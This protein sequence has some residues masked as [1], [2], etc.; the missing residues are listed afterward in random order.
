MSFTEVF[1]SATV[2]SSES[3]LATFSLT[4]DQT[5]FWAYN[6]S[7]STYQ[8]ADIMEFSTTAG[9]SIAMPPANQVSI[10]ESTLIRNIGANQFEVKGAGGA[11]LGTVAAGVAKLFY[12]SDNTTVA[13]VWSVLT[14]GTGTSAADA[15]TLQGLGLLAIGATL[16]DS[17]P[18][19]TTS[20]AY[21]ITTANRANTLVFTGGSVNCTLPTL[22]TAVNG[23]SVLIKN[24]GSGTITFVPQGA[25]VIDQ[26]T[27]APGESVMLIAGTS[28]VT[29]GYGRSSTFAFTRLNKDV[30]AFG[31]A[32]ASVDSVNK[33]VNFHG[34]PTGNLNA[35][36]PSVPA[37]YYLSSSLTVRTVTV[38][39]STGT[40]VALSPGDSVIVVCD[41]VNMFVALSAT[42]SNDISLPSGTA[43]IPS[44]RFAASSGT[45]IYLPSG[46]MLGFSL[47]GVEKLRLDTYYMTFAGLM[48]LGRDP[49]TGTWASSNFNCSGMITASYLGGD[50]VRLE[51]G[52][53][54]SGIV[55]DTAKNWTL[56]AKDFT[57]GNLGLG[58]FS[59]TGA[60]LSNISL[61]MDTSGWTF[62]GNVLLGGI[63][64][65]NQLGFTSGAG[66]TV[67]QATS[68]STGVTLN[69]PCGTI[70]TAGDA[71]TANTSVGFWF[72][73][74][75]IGVN[76]VMMASVQ[77]AIASKYEIK[78]SGNGGSGANSIGV[79]IKNTTGGSL[80]EVLVINFVV[81][82]GSSV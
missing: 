64:G 21:V 33:I 58:G 40:G 36:F 29:V 80:S 6:S 39:T 67:T 35:V 52:L 16:N 28:W 59:M 38:K 43:A 42:Y 50:G 65:K 26:L 74:T 2:P 3:K 57:M 81:I 49:V 71:L 48:E 82:K 46:G 19:V 78:C 5:F 14:F 72:N 12:I 18:V 70:N 63:S 4:T 51:P 11:T 62:D 27:L 68:K 1:G 77:G 37:V 44:I 66:G 17:H 56:T 54:S 32:D 25:E 75:C 13:G 76:D 61:W 8:V 69:K 30:S 60:A 55:L 31:G 7:D 45:G 10:G 53:T 24:N 22:A 9:R 73:N 15:T 47:N 41:G 34:T 20:A 79:Y 23:F